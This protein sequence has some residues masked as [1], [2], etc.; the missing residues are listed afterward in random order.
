[1][2]WTYI[3]HRG[4]TNTKVNGNSISVSPSANLA[5]GT[6]AIVRC[7]ADNIGTTDGESGEHTVSDSKANTWTK[8]RE[9]RRSSGGVPAD[10]V[11]AS[12]WI[13]QISVAILVADTIT[14]TLSSPVDAKAIGIEEFSVAAG[15]GITVQSHAGASL[16]GTFTPSV[17]LSIT[18]G[19]YLWIGHLGEQCGADSYTQDTDYLPVG[20]EPF[21]TT[22]GGATT[23]VASRL[24]YR[25]ATLASDEFKPTVG[26]QRQYAIAL[27]AILETAPGNDRRA[28]VTWAEFEVPD[29]PVPAPSVGRRLNK[30][31]GHD[32][33]LDI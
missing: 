14:L 33:L 25:T 3:A 26:V 12:I 19:L 22:G 27:A 32:R 24:G 30:K 21:Q 20:G 23:N 5:V 11:T 31:R 15:N 9:Q 8:I 29:A 18:E 17:S 2:A 7:V 1:M 16:S 10:G 13:S 4:N 28:M 6:I